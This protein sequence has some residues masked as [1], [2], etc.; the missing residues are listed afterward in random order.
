MSDFSK[1][2]RARTQLASQQPFF[3]SLLFGLK[4]VEDTSQPTLATD[5]TS[6][7]WNP[8]FVEGLEIEQLKFGLCHEVMHCVFA[9]MYTRGHR[10]HTVWNMAG[11]YVINQLLVDESV[12]APTEGCLLDAKLVAD[13][14]NTTAGVYELLLSDEKRRPRHGQPGQPGQ[15]GAESP[16]G[17][18]GCSGTKD[19]PGGKAERSEG[20]ARMKVAVSQAAQAAKMC[21]KLSAGVKRLVEEALTPKVPWREVLRRFISIRAKVEYSFAR[22]KRR[23]LAEDLYL[24]SLGGQA[25]GDILVAVDCSGSIGPKELAEFI[26]ELKAIKADCLPKTVHVLYFHS[27][28]SGHDQF[29]A[30]DEIVMGPQETGGTA[31]SPIFRY[32]D[33]HGIEPVCCVVLT[34]LYCSDFGPPPGYPVLWATT[35]ATDA[36]WGEVVKVKD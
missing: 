27:V 32:A 2:Q 19:A 17:D 5:G 35:G 23:F 3:A 29:G 7:F 10:D 15:P 26:T 33:E 13:G 25:M 24:P 28:V 31:F 9:H 14:G 22:P 6:L 18:C 1:M 30:D 4:M 21:G 34:D 11:D 8:D 12:G 20:E 36:P 16:H